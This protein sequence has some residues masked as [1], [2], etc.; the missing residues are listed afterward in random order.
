VNDAVC[1][2]Q[3]RRNIKNKKKALFTETKTTKRI[4]FKGREVK[5]GKNVLCECMMLF[6][7]VL[8]RFC[9][10]GT[11]SNFQKKKKKKTKE[12]EETL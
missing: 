5:N 3:T 6:C 12:P 10:Y 4:F 8:V 2:R 7:F 11:C 1:A 9:R